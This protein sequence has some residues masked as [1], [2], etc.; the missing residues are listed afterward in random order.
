MGKVTL[1]QY[2]R[3][4]PSFSMADTPPTRTEIAGWEIQGYTRTR[5][6]VRVSHPCQSPASLE[7]KSPGEVATCIHSPLDS[8]NRF[9]RL[10]L[11]VKETSTDGVRCATKLR[12]D[13]N[14]LEQ[15]RLL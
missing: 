10:E 9:S 4:P 6:Q 2:P 13:G 15:L 7:Q 11:P 8:L 12:G 1:L 3:E 14:S 5:A